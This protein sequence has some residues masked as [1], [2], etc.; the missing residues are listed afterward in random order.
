MLVDLVEK[1]KE[2]QKCLIKKLEAQNIEL[3]SII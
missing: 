1:K 3:V 2:N